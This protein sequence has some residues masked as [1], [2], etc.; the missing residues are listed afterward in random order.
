MKS[1]VLCEGKTDFILYSYYLS[2]VCGWESLDKK[3][4]RA[5]KKAIDNRLSK[6]KVDNA[7]TQGFAWYFRGDDF[8]CIYAVG[9]KDNFADGLKQIV[10]INL[11]TSV[12]KFSKVAVISDRDDLRAE[13]SQIKQI[14]DSIAASNIYFTHVLHNTWNESDEY[15]SMG[16][17]YRIYLLPLVIPFEEAGTIEIFLLNCRKEINDGEKTLIEDVCNF[18]DELKENSYIKSN[19]LTERGLVPKS[20]LSAYF[21]VVSPNRTFDVGNKILESIPWEK[22]LEF[23]ETLRLLSEI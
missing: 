3:E 15:E 8:L 4:N 22:Y 2:K 14:T 20:K 9:S 17:V 19:Y 10:D 21:S 12:E 13:E 7:D 5:Y 23:Q 11:K 1:I 16:D 6:M 18:I